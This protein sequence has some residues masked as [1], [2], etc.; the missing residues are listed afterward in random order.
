MKSIGLP[1]EKL[2]TSPS[3]ITL[4][5]PNSKYSKTNIVTPLEQTPNGTSNQISSSQ[6]NTAVTSL[7]FTGVDDKNDE[8]HID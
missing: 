5:A 7:A 4:T 3:T 2:H 1:Y 8:S 6:N